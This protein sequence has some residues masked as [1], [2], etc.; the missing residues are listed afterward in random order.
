MIQTSKTDTQIQH[1]VLAELAWE[2]SVGAASIGVEVKDGVVTL[3]GH[4]SSLHA[5]WEAEHAAQRV[6]GVKALAVE[7]DVKLPGG[8]ERTDAD[9]AR[10][11]QNVI[12]WMTYLPKNAVTVVVDHGW[13]TLTGQVDW[14][15]QKEGAQSSVR[16]LKGVTGVSDQIVLKAQVATRTVK[17]DIEEAFQR[18]ARA[19]AGVISVAIDGAEVTLAGAVH[20]W[21]ERSLARRTAWAT[22]GVQRV[23]DHMT[24]VE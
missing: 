2:P 22:P 19:D 23:I 11:A 10:S 24:V 5:K 9:I 8:S 6:S 14:S 17:A 21:S 18:R 16:A 13:I 1:D 12:E 20:S 3:T 15:F 7:I 4:V